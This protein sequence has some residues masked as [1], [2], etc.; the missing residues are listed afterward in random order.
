MNDTLTDT[1]ADLEVGLDPPCVVVVWDDPVNLM[2][3]V[4]M[5]F[6]RVFGWPLPECERK[7]LEVH[8]EGKSAVFTGPRAE[9][10]VVAAKLRGYQLWAS[11]EK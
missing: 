5:V 3:Y 6:R 4:T 8:H 9:A 1:L 2:S 7:M 11:I 10:E